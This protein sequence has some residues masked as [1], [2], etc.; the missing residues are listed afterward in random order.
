VTGPEE[1]RPCLEELPRVARDAF[2]DVE[3]V[4]KAVPVRIEAVP[5]LAPEDESVERR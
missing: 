4:E 5:V 2:G 1:P 3:R